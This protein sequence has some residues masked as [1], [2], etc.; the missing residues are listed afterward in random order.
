MQ[1]EVMKALKRHLASAEHVDISQ[2][3]FI[4]ME[5]VQAAAGD[6]W[7]SLRDR[8]FIAS[9]SIIEKR[10]AEEDLIIPCASGF[11][12][13]FVETAGVEADALTHAIKADMT[14]FFLG[15]EMLKL[16]QVDAT[17]ERLTVEEFKRTLQAAQAET[18][19]AVSGA[20]AGAVAAAARTPSASDG[21]T[22]HPIKDPAP[23]SV[24]EVEEIIFAPA[25]DPRREA[26]ATFFALPR[27]RG[28]GAEMW[29][30]GSA[31]LRGAARPE[32]RLELELDGLNKIRG[33]FE[34]FAAK[35]GRCGLVVS[36]NYEVIANPRTRVPYAGALSK[37]PER[38]RRTLLVRIESAPLD[39]PAASMTEAFRTL[40]S[41]CAGLFV[42]AP[43]S[44]LSLTR[45][46][47]AGVAW[48]GCSLPGRNPG[49]N[50]GDLDRLMALVKRQRFGAYIDQ[51]TSW[52]GVKAALET[53]A[54]LLSGPAV[55]QAHE[56][57]VA[58]YRLQK[59]GVLARAA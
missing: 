27:S 6:R 37:L 30:Y 39:A 38:M 56:E 7:P 17:S 44:T 28:R 53:D 8:V 25:W 45:L 46:E 59:A 54:R 48:V 14:A 3:Q 24:P 52:E 35:G 19:T 51:L 58:P 4:N 42:H 20:A 40:A 21:V 22:Y 55:A 36:V 47:G 32:Q 16:L 33:H 9:R 18:M 11:L 1:T 34:T 31:I 41:Y 57:L 50:A 10:L 26:V 2:Y 49:Q 12:V 29:R 43:L 13:V 15:E 5:A 23:A